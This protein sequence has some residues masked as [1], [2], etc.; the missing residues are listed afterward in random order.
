VL[1][2]VAPTGQT[3]DPGRKDWE[4]AEDALEDMRPWLLASE[5]LGKPVHEVEL[6]LP[7]AGVN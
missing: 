4:V 1:A 7:S 3:G 2:L 6:E 5:T